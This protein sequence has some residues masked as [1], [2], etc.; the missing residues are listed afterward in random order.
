MERSARTSSIAGATRKPAG[1][2]S[3]M[4]AEFTPL[5]AVAAGPAH[6]LTDVVNAV[7]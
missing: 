2:T 5:R 3:R 6:T 1:S 4:R 7:M